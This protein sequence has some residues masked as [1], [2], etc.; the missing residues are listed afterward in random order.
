[1][2]RTLVKVLCITY[3][4]ALAISEPPGLFLAALCA[5]DVMILVKPKHDVN[6]KIKKTFGAVFSIYAVNPRPIR[7]EI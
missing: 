7:A 4:F 6:N 1:M 2:E 5:A 3:V